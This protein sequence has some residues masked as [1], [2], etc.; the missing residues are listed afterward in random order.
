VVR[1]FTMLPIAGTIGLLAIAFGIGPASAKDFRHVAPDLVEAVRRQGAIRVIVR[2]EQLT[3]RSVAQAQ[4]VV[5]AELAATNHRVLHRYLTSPMLAVEVD[6]AALRTLAA[7]PNVVSVAGDFDLRSL[8]Q[9][10][11]P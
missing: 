2:V 11:K 3:G 6:E 8:P 9:G 1:H 7:S 10:T 4:D 5:L